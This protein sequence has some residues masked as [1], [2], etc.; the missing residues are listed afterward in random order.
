MGRWL[1]KENGTKSRLVARAPPPGSDVAHH[2]PAQSRRRAAVVAPDSLDGDLRMV[3]LAGRLI[4]E[5]HPAI[6]STATR[7]RPP[8]RVTATRSTTTRARSSLRATATRLDRWRLR[9][10]ACTEKNNQILKRIIIRD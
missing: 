9:L 8:L 5:P 10:G 3:A 7:A 6:R 1:R 4:L 2:C